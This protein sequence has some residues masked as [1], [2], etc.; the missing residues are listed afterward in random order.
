MNKSVPPGD[1]PPL[2]TKTF[3]SQLSVP[4]CHIINLKI[5]LGQWSK[6]YKSEYVTPVPKCFP[7]E[8]PD[9]LRNISGLLT[10]DRVS[11]KMIAEL[12]IEDMTQNLDPSQYA[13]QQGLSTTVMVMLVQSLQQL[14]LGRK[15]SQDNVQNLE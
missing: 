4:L 14:L 9:N 10:F 15:L 1:L 2:L 12:I 6:L 8:S 7:T 3:A 13:N 11:E 5:K